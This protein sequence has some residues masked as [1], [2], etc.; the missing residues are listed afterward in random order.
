MF[1]S[2]WI[3]VDGKILWH[4]QSRWILSIILREI[5]AWFI[6]WC[7]SVLNLSRECVI[8]YLLWYIGFVEDWYCCF[9]PCLLHMVDTFIFSTQCLL[10][11]G[12]IILVVVH[13]VFGVLESCGCLIMQLPS[14]MVIWCLLSV[15]TNKLDKIVYTLLLYLF[16]NWG[17]GLS[18]Q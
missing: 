15:C 3:V 9:E 18:C 6:L 5:S 8:A 11:L 17:R 4:H 12:R 14:A 7:G 16:Q 13:F 10:E 2:I 1:T